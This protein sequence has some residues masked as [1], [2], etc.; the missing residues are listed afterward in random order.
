MKAGQGDRSLGRPGR[1]G[2]QDEV[3]PAENR[4]ERF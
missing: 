1:A 2:G 4:A 3:R